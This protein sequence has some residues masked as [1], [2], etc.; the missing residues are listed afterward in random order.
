MAGLLLHCADLCD[1]FLQHHIWDSSIF[2]L[3]LWK[4]AQICQMLACFSGLPWFLGS[5]LVAD[6]NW[7]KPSALRGGQSVLGLPLN[8][9]WI[10]S[11][12]G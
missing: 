10:E 1:N 5:D 4:L 9:S 12:A 3:V 11:I 7:V 8:Q 6:G 2:L